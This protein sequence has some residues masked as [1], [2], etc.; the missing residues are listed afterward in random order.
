MSLDKLSVDT[1]VSAS[2]LENYMMGKAK[3]GIRNVINQAQQLEKKAFE[4]TSVSLKSTDSPVLAPEDGNHV[5]VDL[6]GGVT[7]RVDMS[8]IPEEIR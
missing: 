3:E 8:E 6:G 4:K 7:G 2:E 1:F 5:E